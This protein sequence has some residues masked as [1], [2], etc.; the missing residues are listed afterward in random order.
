MAP[1]SLFTFKALILDK[2]GMEIVAPI[3]KVGS[4]RD[5]NIVLHLNIA[6][7]RERI[8][9]LPVVYFVEPTLSNFK[10]IATDAGKSLYDYILV[11][12][13]TPVTPQQV[14]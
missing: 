2:H 10:Q 3:M 5:C 12:F 8:P 11:N 4:L 6:Q 13:S 1:R 9:D 14:D 7:K